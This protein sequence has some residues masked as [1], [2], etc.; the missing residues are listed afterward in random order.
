[1]AGSPNAPITAGAVLRLIR[2]GR[3]TT[4]NDL[5]TLLGAGRTTIAQRVD[6]LLATRLVHEAGAG[7]STGGRRPTMLAFSADTGV[8]LSADL[9]ATHCRLAVTDLN[10]RILASHAGN[11]DIALGPDQVLTSVLA[12]FGTL[13][14]EIE[15]TPDAVLG[16]G[17]GVPGPVEFATGRPVNPPIMP[18]WDG[19]SVPD[20]FATAHPGVPVVVDNDVNIMAL[21]EYTRVWQ[22]TPYFLLVKVGTGIGCGIIVDGLVRRGAQGAAGDIGHVQI[23]GTED[24]VCRCGNVACLEAL[25]GGGAMAK[26]LT[27]AGFDAPN[28]RHVV[29]LAR[30]GNP[31]ATQMVRE[32]GRLLGQVL[33]GVV[34]FLNPDVIIIGG[35]VSEA[36]QQLLA[37][38]REIVYRRS[39]PLATQHLRIARS[40]LGDH[41]GVIG[42]AEMA[43]ERVLA[44]DVVD[45]LVGGVSINEALGVS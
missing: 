3:A 15:I 22:G 20:W 19:F 24:A 16:I 36:E 44:D 4:R 37:G 39:L 35:D 41:A 14:D 25:A 42:A 34:N 2:E 11:L 9:G 33:A 23:A 27:E 31:V 38:V 21:G 5:A 13:L 6:A 29:E 30:Q 12:T 28:A 32:S 26:R 45:R 18:G 17:V 10:G 7:V 8:V 43:I 40:E 1:M